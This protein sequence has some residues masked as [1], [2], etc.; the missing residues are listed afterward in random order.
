V[1]ST[2]QVPLEAVTVATTRAGV[3]RALPAYR[4]F[5]R[6][7]RSILPVAPGPDGRRLGT[8]MAAG[9]E[10]APVSPGTLVACTSGSTGTPKG[11]MLQTHGILAAVTA[12]ADYIRDRTGADPGPWLLALPA[13]H[14]AGTMVILRSL[15]AGH[16]P[17]VMDLTRGHFTSEGFVDATRRLVSRHPDLPRYTSLVPTQLARLVDAVPGSVSGSVSGNVSGTTAGDAVDALRSYAAVLV[18]GGAAPEALVRR[19]RSLGVTLMLTYGSSETAGGV[20]YDGEPLPGYSVRISTDAGDRSSG[21]IELTGPSVAEGYRQT[22]SLPAEA[23]AD[24]FPRPGTFRTSDLGSLTG[25]VLT[26]RGRA[27]GA[28]NSAGLKILPEEVEKA[29][30]GAGY[31]AC[32][33]GVPDDEWGESVAALVQD[34]TVPAGTDLTTG[35]R[36]TLKNT[37]TPAHL[38]PRHSYS[39]PDIP[40]TGPGKPDRVAVTEIL[41]DLAAGPRSGSTL[42]AAGTFRPDRGWQRG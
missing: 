26:V 35:V 37:G 12:S 19:C 34:P 40:V 38:I 23:T 4:G 3:D 16:V 8:L 5:L 14:I 30:A 25:G 6:G 11:A 7:S 2:D 22:S 39:F 10:D 36:A 13:H 41:R 33:G 20:V 29:L 24:A 17:E 32:A 31:S 42:R 15:E 18:G 28:V 1:R 27:D 9:D 21:R